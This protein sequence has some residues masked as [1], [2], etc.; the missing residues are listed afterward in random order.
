MA[1]LNQIV[2]VV[3]GK[4]TR[5]EKERDGIYKKL[6]KD[7]LFGGI[8][9]SYKP[10][11]EN[12]ETFP[13]EKKNVQFTAQDACDQFAAVLT[14]LLDATA[15]QDWAN[16]K[17]RA[18][19]LV[20]GQT[21]LA[22]VPVTYLMFIEKQL[23]DVR[24]FIDHIPT[25]DLADTWTW[26]GNSNCYRSESYRSHKTKKSPQVIVKY[27][28]T[29]EHPAQTELLFED[30]KVGEWTSTKFSGAVPMQAK[31]E[32][33]GRVDKLIDA[34]KTAREEA[35]QIEVEAKK[36]GEAV[37]NFVFSPLAKHRKV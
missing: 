17:A 8:A 21:V 35:N 31:K 3:A 1:K 16:T 27:E 12:G 24:T 15:T 30:K 34:V 2:A 33:L 29:E 19:V 37:F 23:V 32:M 5:L 7:D 20:D 22:D 14:E 9:R 10:D 18:D 28:A 36:V 25:L 26:D 13:P 4:K 6:Q 11:D